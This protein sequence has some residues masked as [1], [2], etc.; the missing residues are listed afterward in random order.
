MKS[1]KG[2][3]FIEVV[4][5]LAVV[6]ILLPIVGIVFYNLIVTPPEQAARLALNNEVAILSQFL[7]DDAHKSSNF[8]V[9]TLP[10]YGNFTWTDYS[11][12]YEYL[13]SYYA[14]CPN[15]SDT[16][17]VNNVVRKVTYT[18]GSGQVTP[19]PVGTA[20]PTPTPTPGTPGTYDYCSG[21]VGNNSAWA[22][23]WNNSEWTAGQPTTPD[24]F[25]ATTNRSLVDADLDAYDKLCHIDNSSWGS[26]DTTPPIDYVENSQLYQFQ[27]TQDRLSV[28]NLSLVWRGYGGD[29][30]YNTKFKIWNYNSSSWSTLVSLTDPASK[31]IDTYTNVISSSPSNY[32]Q[33][34]TNLVTMMTS[35]DIN[36]ETPRNIDFGDALYFSGASYHNVSTSSA[37]PTN[38]FTVEAWVRA[39]DTQDSDSELTDRY[40]GC[41]GEHYV[42]MPT[43]KGNDAGMGISVGTNGISVYEHGN[44]YMPAVAVYPCSLGTAWNHIAVVYSDHS[45]SIYLNGNLVRSVSSATINTSYAANRS[46]VYAPTTVDWS[47]PGTYG[48]FNGTVDEVRIWD[49]A[50]TGTQIRDNMYQEIANPT[51]ETNLKL[52]WKFNDCVNDVIDGIVEDSSNYN[53][54]GTLTSPAPQ[55]V[56]G[57][58]RDLTVYTDYIGLTVN[59]PGPTPT[60]TLT[61][62]PPEPTVTA[63]TT[64]G[65]TTWT[66][67]SGTTQVDAVLVVAGGG[68]G[69]GSGS[70]T[71]Y[72]GG[73]GGGGGLIYRTNFTLPETYVVTYTSSG[74][75]TVPENVSS[76]QV[77]VVGGG[78]GGGSGNNY[79]YGCG[80]GGGAGGLKYNS[81]V[82]VTPGETIT[83]TVGGGGAGGGAGGANSGTNGSA[84]SWAGGSGTITANGGG[85]GGYAAANG[86]EGGS[87]GAPGVRTSNNASPGWGTVG[88]GN[89]G[90]FSY[91]DGTAS[92][93]AAGGGG[94]NGSPGG[95]AASQVGGNGGA[96]SS[97][98]GIFGSIGGASG[99]FAGG[100]GGGC[101]K[102]S[103]GGTGQAG[104]GNGG[105]EGGGCCGNG[106]P[107][108]AATGSTGSGGGGG[109]SG[110]WS[111]SWN[112]KGGDGGSGIVAI[113]YS[114]STMSVTVGA[115][116]TAGDTNSQGGDGGSSKFGSI[117]ATGGGGGAK[118]AF[119]GGEENGRAGGSGGGAGQGTCDSGTGGSGTAGQGK[120]GANSVYVCAL[121]IN[122]AGAGGGG[123]TSDGS[124]PD[125]SG[126]GGSGGSGGNY[127]SVFGTG[128]GV[129]GWFAGGGGG[130]G[131]NTNGS[132]GQGGGGMGGGYAQD[133]GD[134]QAATPNTGGG[135][136]GGYNGWQGARS[137]GA[138]G[139]GIVIIKYNKTYKYLSTSASD[140]G[141]V[142]P[143]PPG[144]WYTTGSVA[145][146]VAT[147]STCYNFVNW[148]GTGVDADK[149]DNPN[150]PSTYIVMDDNY[151]VQA[152]FTT[153]TGEIFLQPLVASPLSGGEPYFDG[154]NPFTCGTYVPIHAKPSSGFYFSQWTS[155]PSSS[156]ANASAADTTVFMTVNCTVTA[157]YCTSPATPT[158]IPPTVTYLGTASLTQ[159][160]TL[161]N[162]SLWQDQHTGMIN[163]TMIAG[164]KTNMGKY[165]EKQLQ[166][167]VLPRPAFLLPEPFQ[168]GEDTISSL[169]GL[170]FTGDYAS[171][172][173]TV[174]VNGTVTVA[175]SADYNV[176]DGDLWCINTDPAT[177]DP[178][179]LSYTAIHQGQQNV[180]MPDPGAMQIYFGTNL[181]L[182][183]ETLDDSKHEY[184]FFRDVD[185]HSVSRV[186]EHEDPE[187]N[188]TLKSGMYYSNGTI[189]LSDT[190][191]RGTVTFI[192]DRIV[193]RNNANTG[194]ISGKIQLGPYDKDL[195]FWANHSDSSPGADFSAALLIY[196]TNPVGGWSNHA[197]V[198]LEGVLYA[199]NGEIELA[200]SGRTGWIGLVDACELYRGALVSKYV[201][202][203]GSRWNFYRW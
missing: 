167:N 170:L 166:I 149:V 186:W 78:G 11:T 188:H 79:T 146:I 192:A 89:K 174:K 202:I 50:R 64:V 98:V 29:L 52:Y 183:I 115:G 169:S 17:C 38:T 136:G 32:I 44:N 189:T 179:K 41:S 82:P 94:G 148:T 87:G 162:F 134:G 30:T 9:G 45:P 69:G 126:H 131:Q 112:N 81:S 193:I 119:G 118:G 175:S 201:T 178:L 56:T 21:A 36:G 129:S 141:T 19:T 28:T 144:A 198:A 139:S 107:G 151:S 49:V 31:T 58:R 83:I 61:P 150:S 97:Y 35:S 91:Q 60:P 34:D 203:S 103:T 86:R 104:G 18:N 102:A 48:S 1:L 194:L 200:G 142:S 62:K 168:W 67:P 109:V 85:G 84:S 111:V 4:T 76:V 68:G 122:N 172:S 154:S 42:F 197:C 130:G 12:G 77:L 180:S 143:A 65:T 133:S 22:K 124:P 54:D 113:K 6:M 99:S 158:P 159:H 187:Y 13:I 88:Q 152:N 125:G 66:P 70:T 20:T 163:A 3:S 108:G 75:W 177:L 71:A 90:G 53:N 176:I 57:V 63:F 33:S 24:A 116:G 8:S 101:F 120:N 95:N 110:G 181:S 80:G 47:W 73:G 165:L 127:G 117:T 160:I 59:V 145:S 155:V 123:N 27:V 5:A 93:N 92:H 196:D 14:S 199:P 164:M 96:G 106:E 128:Y 173:G 23:T 182:G 114:T 137:G 190:S 157:V 156:F 10:Y 185:L 26:Q 72:V 140:G 39:Q 15:A 55:C 74:S 25:F 184:V 153:S 100:G 46:I 191:T 105:G 7:Y 138:G 43:Q 121:G 135:G 37:M 195:L 16:T 51:S 40:A 161:Y 2:L 132:G 171:I 147:N